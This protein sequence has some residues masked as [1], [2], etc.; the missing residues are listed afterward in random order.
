[1]HLIAMRT[2]EWCPLLR[3]VA[4]LPCLRENDWSSAAGSYVCR[5]TRRCSALLPVHP[6]YSSSASFPRIQI[7]LHLDP[8]RRFLRGLLPQDILAS[9]RRDPAILHRQGRPRCAAIRV[10]PSHSD[11][12]ETMVYEG[13]SALEL[14]LEVAL[15]PLFNLLVTIRRARTGATTLT[16]AARSA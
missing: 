4:V 6:S 15:V 16:L 1:M 2:L 10:L 7:E 11:P 14:D 12:H 13:Q 5:D 3:K 8:F 9:S